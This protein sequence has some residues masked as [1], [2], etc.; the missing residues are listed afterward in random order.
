MSSSRG[1]VAS[2]GIASLC[3]VIAC[4]VW[5][6]INSG[7]AEVVEVCYTT[8]S[9]MLFPKNITTLPKR[10]IHYGAICNVSPAYGTATVG[11]NKPLALVS[12]SSVRSYSGGLAVSQVPVSAS[13]S[14]SH[15]EAV[16]SFVRQPVA[17]NTPPA[18]ALG[19]TAA[20]EYMAGATVVPVRHRAPGHI[21]GDAQGDATGT[22]VWSQWLGE[23]WS[24]GATDLS[25]LEEWWNGKYG[26]NGYTPD[27]FTD[28]QK[29]AAP[30][31]DGVGVLAIAALLYYAT[32]RKKL[33]TALKQKT[34]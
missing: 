19:Y 14:V 13:A 25:G 20:T 6:R 8:G 3:G 32:K 16:P 21:G 27:I 12:A 10:D 5:H 34:V 29:W 11:Y 18:L 17:K 23:Y 9:A 33:R 15:K 7:S 26:N 22:S 4:V 30:L 24:T 2:L 28:F 1:I 31:P